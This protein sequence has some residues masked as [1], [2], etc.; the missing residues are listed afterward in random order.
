MDTLTKSCSPTTVI[1]ANGEVQTHEEATV[2]VKELEK[3]L[4]MKVLEDTPAV[5]SLGKLCDEHGYSYEWING[6][7]PH[8]IKKRYSDTVQHGELRS[9]R[10]FWSVNEFSLQ[11]YLF[12]IFDT[13]KAGDWSSYIFLKLV[14][15]TNHNCV[16]RQWD[17]SKWRSE[18][19]RF[20]TSNCVKWPSWTER[21]GRP[22]AQANQKNPK[23]NK[24]D[25]HE[26][27]VRPVLF[28][29]PGMAARIQRKSGGW[30]S[31]W[32]QRLTRQFL[33]WTIFTA[34]AYEK[35]WFG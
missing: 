33:S 34:Y 1:T 26:R 28:R 23:P 13:L 21:T 29:N 16:K 2:Y 7:K 15:F 32:T 14:Y 35:C 27:T 3:F 12:N 9:D 6:Q 22:V 20:L 10:G 19:D 31:S 17:S 24:N 25:N 11:F 4:T 8:L 30:Q 5:L 18:W